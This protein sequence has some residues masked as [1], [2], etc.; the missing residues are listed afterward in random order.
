VTTLSAV[1]GQLRNAGVECY[2][3]KEWGSPREADGSYARRRSTHPMPPGPASYHF[4]HITVTGDTDLPDEGKA[5]ARQVESFGLS[6]PPMVSYQDLVTNEGRYFQGQNYGT[7]GTHTVNDKNVPGFPHDLNLHGYATA[8]MQ[9]VGDAVTDRQVDVIAMVFAAREI[10]GLVQRG[11]PIHPHRTFANKACPG[12]KA[13]ARLPEIRALR[14]K[15]VREGLPSKE[16]PAMRGLAVVTFNAV[17]AMP[18][19]RKGLGN[20]I[21]KAAAEKG[22]LLL[23]V[24]CDDLEPAAVLDPEVWWW[25]H[26]QAEHL[27]GNFIAGLRKRTRASDVEVIPGAPASPV[28]APRAFLKAK[29][30]VDDTWGLTVSPYHSPRWR[31]GGLEAATAMLL[32]AQSLDIDLLAGDIN[33]RN[34]AVRRRFPNR[35]VRSREVMHMMAR[36]RLELGNAQAF[37]L[38]EGTVSDDHPGL[39]VVVSPR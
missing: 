35:T 2:S 25:R 19:N 13:V 12:D 18:T 6:T 39:R 33:I 30:R 31:E 36:Q 9:N 34:D 14:D 29:I 37:D 1:L 7:K 17:G 3:R 22:A 38:L 26:K 4:L 21:L 24:E 23:G 10:A 20:R 15:Y 27:D 5:A 16:E 28:N 11:A 32:K 8:I